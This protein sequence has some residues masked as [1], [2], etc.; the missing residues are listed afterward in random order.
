MHRAAKIDSNQNEI[1]SGLR[2]C[3]YSVLITS[4]LKKCF[5]ILVGA[6]KRNYAFEIKDPNKPPSSRRLTPG[7]Q[8]FFDTW[9]GQINV[10]HTVEEA[11]VIIRDGLNK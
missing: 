9:N 5:D 6:H 11:L 7:E 4:Q 10:I 8:K 3:G 1:V 2:K